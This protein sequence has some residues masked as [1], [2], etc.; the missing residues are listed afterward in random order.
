MLTANSLEVYVFAGSHRSQWTTGINEQ[1]KRLF[2]RFAL[3]VL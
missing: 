2:F 3:K 1:S